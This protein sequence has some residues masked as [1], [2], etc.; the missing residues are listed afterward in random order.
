MIGR[1][2]LLV[3]LIL[4]VLSLAPFPGSQVPSR[5]LQDAPPP[6]ENGKDGNNGGILKIL[7]KRRNHDHG[8]DGSHPPKGPKDSRP[9]KGSDGPDG[10]KPPKGH[11]GDG[12]DGS[13]PPKG[14][15]G[16]DGSKPPKGSG[17]PP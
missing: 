17:P 12:P 8:P 1:L 11:K 15:D 13:R 3:S 14:S 4:A 9:P 10:S 7:R 2:F 6:L 5:L 16:P